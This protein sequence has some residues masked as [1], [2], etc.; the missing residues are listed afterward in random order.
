VATRT[1]PGCT[2]TI[3]ATEPLDALLLALTERLQCR[4]NRL[5]PGMRARYHAAA[6]YVSQFVNVLFDEAATLWATWGATEAQA[7]QALL[8]LARGT[9]EAIGGAGIAR[10][11]PGPVSRGD[12]GSIDKHLQA[13]APLDGGRRTGL[14][15]ALCAAT[16]D[17]AARSGTLDATTARRFDEL[18]AHAADGVAAGAGKAA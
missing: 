3:E 17:I 14:Y 4:V 16:V 13:L 18:L 11:M 5:P 10:A 12:V 1:L 7:V 9:L 8:P 15:R 6:G 2:I